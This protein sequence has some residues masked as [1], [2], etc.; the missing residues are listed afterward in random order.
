MCL[1][2]IT[3]ADFAILG[4]LYTRYKDLQICFCNDYAVGLLKRIDV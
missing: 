4:I 3:E 2:G 1:N